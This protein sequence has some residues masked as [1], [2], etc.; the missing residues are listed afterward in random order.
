MFNHNSGESQSSITK[1]ERMLKTNLIYYFDSQEFEDIVIH[2]MG[3]G[4]NQLAKKALRMG[5]QQHPSSLALMLLQSEVLILEEKYDLALS[6]LDY[7]EK[8]HPFE[9]EIALQRATISSKKGNHLKSI[10]YLNQ[11]LNYSEDPE[12]IWNLLGMEHILAEKY[13]DASYFF[14]NCLENN[15]EDYPSLYNLLFC[16]E[17]LGKIEPAI[18]ALNN[19]LE[20]NPYCE[21]AWHELGKI[22]SK[23]GK[24]KE[25]LSALEFAIICDDTF[26]SAYIEK[27]TI[28]EAGGKIN[29]AIDNYNIALKSNETS[30]FIYKSIGRCH[31]ILGNYDLTKQF[32]LKSVQLEPNNEKCWKSL[33]LFMMSQNNFTKA[34]YY[35]EN[36]LQANS[37][38]VDLWKISLDLN[39]SKWKKNKAI[40]ACKKLFELGHCNPDITLKLIDLLIEKKLWEKAYNISEDAYALHINNIDIAI[41]MAGCC[42]HLNK[43]EEGVYL[44][45]PIK[46]NLNR[47]NLFKK[48]FPDYKSLIP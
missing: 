11:A 8:I 48:L 28:L 10:K 38:A 17:Q 18:L 13:N 4:E 37:D 34:Q 46:L 15:P 40:Q 9:E 5:L 2:Y 23:I 7:I 44:L 24:S 41:R 26:T 39:I 32:Y 30:A 21:V 20:L 19:I 42:F 31:E 45:N 22:Y 12:E 1:F 25:A 6:L 27:G 33:I 29:E 35:L 43:M 14:K 16:Y 3:F 36:A 47:K